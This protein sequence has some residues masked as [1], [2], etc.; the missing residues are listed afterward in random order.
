[1]CKSCK[2]EIKF[3]RITYRISSNGVTKV[4]DFGLAEDIYT[5]EYFRQTQDPNHPVKLP[6]KWMALESIHYRKF[7][8]KTDI[9][10]II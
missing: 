5:E 2:S 8:E 6:L 1:M 7:D 9:V 10:S 4:S 3:K